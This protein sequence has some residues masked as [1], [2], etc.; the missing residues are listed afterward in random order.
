MAMVAR[1]RVERARHLLRETDEPVKSI[2]QRVG[3]ANQF[4]FSTAFKRVTG[5]S[6]QS[7]RDAR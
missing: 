6:P 2:A 1:L 4:A 7:C 5:L 3:Y